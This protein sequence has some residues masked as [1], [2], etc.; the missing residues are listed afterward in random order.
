MRK[1]L[2]RYLGIDK[3]SEQ[4]NQVE[5]DL[6]DVMTEHQIE[7]L[8]NDSIE[9]SDLHSRVDDIQDLQELMNELH[10]QILNQKEK[11]KKL[12]KILDTHHPECLNPKTCDCNTTQEYLRN[13]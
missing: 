9:G 2:K 1:F 8:V 3:I 12:E 10:E 5:S 6:E 13:K 4:V 7:T 11:I